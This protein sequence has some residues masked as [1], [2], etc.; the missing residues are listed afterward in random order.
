MDPQELNPPHRRHPTASPQ[1]PKRNQA[2]KRRRME[3]RRKETKK[4]LAQKRKRGWKRRE[5]KKVRRRK[6]RNQ[7]ARRKWPVTRSMTVSE[8][9]PGTTARMIA[10]RITVATTSGADTRGEAGMMFS[11]SNR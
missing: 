1:N 9:A 8:G 5:R 10:G 7:R 2:V 11:V 4:N 3:R 6:R